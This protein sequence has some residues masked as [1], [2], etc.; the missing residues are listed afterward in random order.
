MLRENLQHFAP[1]EKQYERFERIN[2]LS[3]AAWE[4]RCVWCDDCSAC[5]MAIHQHLYTT[6]KH[7]CVYGMSRKEFE[8][9]MDNADV[10]F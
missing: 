1:T 7:T 5:D 2:A 8:T 9:C 6:I 3:E 4:R 10:D